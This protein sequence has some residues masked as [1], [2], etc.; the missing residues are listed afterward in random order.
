[1]ESLHWEI[2]DTVRFEIDPSKPQ[3]SYVIGIKYT[4]AYD[5]RNLYVRY[6]LKDSTNQV[7]ENTLVN[8]PLF[9]RSSGKPLGKGFGSSFTK[10]D[11]LPTASSMGVARVEFIQYMRIETLPGIEAVGLK[12]VKK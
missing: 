7:M 9:E 11:T 6:L 5:F 10:Y 1:M 4:D 3:G 2:A 12:I 8:I